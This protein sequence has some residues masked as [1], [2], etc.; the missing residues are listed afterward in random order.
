MSDAQPHMTDFGRNHMRAIE[1]D[2]RSGVLGIG[3]GKY[4]IYGPKKFIKTEYQMPNG[5]LVWLYRCMECCH[6][7]RN[8]MP[9]DHH[10]DCSMYRED[11]LA[12]WVR[13]GAEV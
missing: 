8:K 13:E 7:I 1:R 6:G 5:R 12:K 3:R 4:A 10:K 11:A 9:G 2:F